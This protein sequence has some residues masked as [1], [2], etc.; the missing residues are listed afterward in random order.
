MADRSHVDVTA[1]TSERHRRSDRA[2]APSATAGADAAADGADARALDALRAILLEPY[3]AQL[4]VLQAEVD[5]LQAALDAVEERI[6]DKERLRATIAPIIA[7]SIHSSIQ[8][9]RHEMINALHPIIADAIR[10][11][12]N[13]SRE[14][15]I[16]AL[17]PITGRLVQRSVTEAMRDLA[18][19]LDAQMR[20]TFNLRTIGRRVHACLRGI[21]LAELVL[22]ESLPYDVSE[23][24]WI[25]RETGILLRY[26]TRKAGADPHAAGGQAPLADGYPDSEVIGSMLTAIQDFVE[27]AFGEE[28]DE[29][30]GD[31]EYG[32][33]R[34]LIEVARYTYVAIVLR[35][36]EPS[37]LRA[38]LRENLYEVERCC[39][40]MLRCFDGDTAPFAQ[41]HEPFQALLDALEAA[42]DASALVY[43]ASPPRRIRRL[44]RAG[45][46]LILAALIL[47]AGLLMV[48]GWQLWQTLLLNAAAP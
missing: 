16:D 35:G 39:D 29:H 38:A 1:N 43:T 13:A 21:P 4:D 22:R 48:L 20:A 36:V 26:H 33:K 47:Y 30:L 17:Y 23:L 32:D 44:A 15:M 11:N 9:S 5:A 18:Q 41:V 3:Q 28:A 8:N 27:H 2:G 24:F 7:A 14:Q 19:R 34:I 6:H 37:G 40:A 12:V 10:T 31:V 46:L 42:P 45:T 25:H